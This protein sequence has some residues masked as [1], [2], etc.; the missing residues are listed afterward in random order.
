MCYQWQQQDLLLH[1]WVQTRASK[2]EW[3]GEYEQQLKLRTTAPAVENK[4]N[5]AII[6]F[7]AKCFAVPKAQIELQSGE[8]N[9][10]KRVL[11]KRPKQ[12][13]DFILPP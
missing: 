1:L 9:R 12:L 3:A 10:R 4:A 11:I 6:K 13:P 7:L 5:Q 2:T 8:H